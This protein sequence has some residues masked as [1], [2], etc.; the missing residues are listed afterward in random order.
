M[1]AT[2][3]L[4]VSALAVALAATAAC[5]TFP[6]TATA[7]APAP[8][9]QSPGF[10]RVMVGD[11]EVTV[12]SDGTSPFETDK[13]LTNIKPA[14]VDKALAKHYLKS[15]VE[16]S[17]NAFLVNTGNK[18]VLVD[19]G[20]STLLGPALGKLLL[21]MTAAGYAPEQVDEVYITHLHADHVGGLM[22]GDK[23]AF[24]NAIVRADRHDAD[25]WLS[26]E[27]LKKSP[28]AAKLFFEGARTSLNPYIKAGKFKPFDGDT[29]LVPGV[30]AV[31][32]R[33]HTPGHAFYV[34]ESK[35]Q[36]IVFWGDLVHVAA[37]QLPN[38]SVTVI[39]DVDT[40]AAASQRKKALAGF[41][42]QGTLIGAAHL[43]FPGIGRL[44]AEGKGYTWL[45][46]DYSAKP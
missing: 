38:P 39:F 33:G 26:D 25:Y 31:A 21:N 22:N 8:K 2:D 32:M 43:S 27:N 4:R 29:E 30:K 12:L 6:N 40:K 9:T 46:L 35:G 13:W 34:A 28:E 42:K 14:Q 23:L 18:L 16:T 11:F 41:A 5:A 45:P 24:P 19:T 37:V 15:P 7:G 44:R 20:S 10:Y 1:F 17:F 36:K 3:L